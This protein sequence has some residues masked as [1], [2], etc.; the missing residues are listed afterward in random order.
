MGALDTSRDP[1]EICPSQR[2]LKERQVADITGISLSTLRKHRHLSNGIPYIKIERSVF[3]AYIDVVE[4]MNSHKIAYRSTIKTACEV[5]T[6]K[7]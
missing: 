6:Q 7:E 3:Y 4:Y 1:K 2:W 5:L